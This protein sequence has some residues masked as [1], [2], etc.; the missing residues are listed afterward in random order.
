MKI[1]TRKIYVIISILLSSLVLYTSAMACKYT[2]RDIGFTDLGSNAYQLC[3]YV[4]DKISSEK[5]TTIERLAFAAFLDA[6]VQTEIIHIDRQ[7][8]HA[9]MKY[10]RTQKDISIPAAVLVDPEGN[11]LMIPF[12][13]DQENMNESLWRLIEKVISSPFRDKIVDQVSETYGSVLLIEG[14]NVEKNREAK[15]AI[16]GAITDILEVMKLMPKPVKEPPQ[17]L[18]ITKEASPS[19]SVLLWSLGVSTEVMDEPQIAIIYSRGRRI[20]PVLRGTE[21]TRENI[22]SLLAIIGADCEC[23]L[24]RSVMLGKMIPLRWERKIQEKLIHILGFD[25]ENPLIKSEMRQILSMTPAVQK[26]MNSNS[27]LSAYREGV[28]KFN[29]AVSVAPT[30]AGDQ[31]RTQESSEPDSSENF[32]LRIGVYSFGTILIIVLLI[33]IVIYIRAKKRR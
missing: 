17:M 33:G 12:S 22:F 31:F 21:I 30:I 15:Q 6:N 13:Y 25:V 26:G 4:D 14:I 24:D 9:A 20:G 19:E 16:K 2:V 18:A 5:V 8:D 11:S 10:L 3:L 29:P 27:P 32:F 1:L 28:I 23:G 7:K